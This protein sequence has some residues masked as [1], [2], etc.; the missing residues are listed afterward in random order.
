MHHFAYRGG[1]LHA[2]G[3]DLEKLATDIGTPFYCYSTATL[4]RHYDIFTEAFSGQNAR[5]YYSVKANSNQAVLKSLIGFGAGMDVVSGGE[6]QRALAAGASGADIVFSGV[7]KTEDEIRAGI[8]NHILSFNVESHAELQQISEIAVSLGKSAAIAIRVNPDV[9]AKTH[10]KITTG[11]AENKFGVPFNDARGLYKTAGALPGIEIT[12]I[13]MHIGSQI[14][15]LEPF[16]EAFKLMADLA[17]DLTADGHDIRHLDLGGG[18]GIPYAKGDPAPPLP[19]AFADIVKSCLGHLGCRLMLEPGRMI[20]GN[21]G[22][23][24]ARVVNV[25]PGEVK[26][27]AILDAAMNDLIRPTLYEAHHDFLPVSKPQG[28]EQARYDIVGPICESGDYL[29]RSRQMPPLQA[30]DLVAAMTAG[31]YGAVQS[32]TYNSRPLVAEV[33]VHGDTYAVIRPRQRIE[34][35]IG[36]DRIPDWL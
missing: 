36:L 10:V 23:L 27:F 28:A 3:V 34:D 29:A 9:D 8:Q 13:A 35:L 2:E 31:A 21:A 18:L 30:G 19:S 4:K 15:D 33:L 14:T 25:K 17:T 20:A 7:G 22:I 5:I 6:L 26:T 24:V 11:R 16:G 32:G 12:G 1:V